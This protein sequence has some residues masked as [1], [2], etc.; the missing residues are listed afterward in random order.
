MKSI[1]IALALSLIL[2]ACGLQEEG[3]SN[4]EPVCGT[5][6]V[7]DAGSPTEDSAV[8]EEDSA[9]PE[10][11]AAV[12]EE[13]SAVPTE[14]A[15]T[16]VVPPPLCKDGA[17]RIFGANNFGASIIYIGGSPCGSI[18]FYEVPGQASVSCTNADPVSG[19][20]KAVDGYIRC[21]LATSAPVGNYRFMV[22]NE[23]CSGEVPRT[24]PAVIGKDQ[25]NAMCD[26]QMLQCTWYNEATQMCQSSIDPKCDGVFAKVANGTLT[27]SGNM[28]EAPLLTPANCH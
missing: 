4:D 16:P 23:S 8:P 15:G 9:V 20:I 25:I 19:V 13:D 1:K 14:D 26:K 21:D 22:F 2:S 18:R 3:A 5:C 11:D 6:G 17:F 28:A 24:N 10:E 7:D 12:P 27:E